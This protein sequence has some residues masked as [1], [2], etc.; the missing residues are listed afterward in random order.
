MCWNLNQ[1]TIDWGPAR[2]EDRTI[3]R[4]Q[5]NL[6]NGDEHEEE[7]MLMTGTEELAVNDATGVVLQSLSQHTPNGERSYV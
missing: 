7:E 4:Y 3:P 6:E 1:P 2:D 5:R